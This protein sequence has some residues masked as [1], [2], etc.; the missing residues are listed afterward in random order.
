L[1]D[2]SIIEIPEDLFQEDADIMSE[3]LFDT[4]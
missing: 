3:E 1:P 4:K 2:P